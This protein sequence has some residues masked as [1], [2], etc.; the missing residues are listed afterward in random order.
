VD[1]WNGTNN[2][3]QQSFS[4]FTITITSSNG[5][6]PHVTPV[7]AGNNT[8][9]LVV[10]NQSNVTISNF[11][12]QHTYNYSAWTGSLSNSSPLISVSGE[13]I[14]VVNNILFVAGNQALVYVNPI[15]YTSNYGGLVEIKYSTFI[16]IS[17]SRAPLVFDFYSTQY[18]FTNVTFR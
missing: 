7:Y 2:V 9:W 12:L 14:F 13:S 1:I 17:L 10:D 16:N 3:G 18:Y 4:G 15:I 8:P 11:I 6:Y 5:V